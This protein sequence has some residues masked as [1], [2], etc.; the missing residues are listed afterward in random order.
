MVECLCLCALDLCF[1]GAVSLPS[2]ANVSIQ[3]DSYGAEVRWKY[4]DLSQDIQFQVKV[5]DELKRNSNI[6][7]KL[8]RNLHLNISSMMFNA[9]FNR[10]YVTV[11]AVRGEEKSKP[12]TSKIFSYNENSASEIK[13]YLDFPE[14]ELS[15]KDGK[16]HVQFANPLQLYRNS[17]AVRNLND[18]LKYCI[19]TEGES[20][21][22]DICEINQNTCETSVVF[23][24]RRGE[25]CISLT[26]MVMQRLF[27]EKSSCFTGDIRSSVSL[28]SPANVSIQCDSYGVE[29]RWKYPDLSQDVQF[30]VEV[31]DDLK[32]NSNITQ[33]R[34]KDLHLNIS[35][36]MFNAQFNRYYVTV[37]AVRGGE[38]SKPTTSKIFSYNENSANEIKCYLDFPEV[39]LS[40]KDGKLHVQFA[41]PLQL[42]RNS[43][44]LRNL[45]DNLKY[46]IET[47]E[48]EN[49]TCGRCDITQKICEKS[50]VFSGHRGEY[51]IS[52]TGTAGQRK[53]NEKSSCFTGD[54]R[55]YPS[56][57]VYLYPVLGVVLTLL[58]ITAII[59]LLVTKD[60]ATIK[61]QV[62]D[63][64][65]AMG[66]LVWPN[67][68]PPP[69]LPPDREKMDSNVYM[70]PMISPEEQKVYEITDNATAYSDTKDIG[71]GN[72]EFKNYGANDLVDDEPYNLSEGYDCPHA[73]R[74]EMSS[75]DMVDAMDLNCFL[76]L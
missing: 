41:N 30:Q 46:C 38:E 50:I 17:P 22:C 8:T 54:I 67:I 19:E 9:Q 31:I 36:M 44:A 4:P 28:P 55:S 58:F 52:L 27:N 18:N 42:Y 29:V 20:E 5:N 15:P 48:E 76:E 59:M 73:P 43:P 51:C 60:K 25:Y 72:S 35:S 7:Q 3:C 69:L 74:Q 12:T 68:N 2:P 56:I 14:V 37:M 23:S 57:T 33:K 21:I 71:S 65:E 66:F 40:P 26:G 16:L 34:T 63:M 24:E 1:A 39:E 6:T 49:E 61:K 45:N 70:E 64:M 53:F 11:M 32:K 47:E 62:S 10:Y 13:C 75:G